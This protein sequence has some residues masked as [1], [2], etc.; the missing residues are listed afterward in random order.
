MCV[1]VILLASVENI[2]V[3]LVTNLLDM[4]VHGMFLA[5]LFT[6]LIL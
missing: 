3:S 4:S 1:K 6:L 5:L 2:D